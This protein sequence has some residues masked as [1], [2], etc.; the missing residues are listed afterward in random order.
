MTEFDF[1]QQYWSTLSKEWEEYKAEMEK[2]DLSDSDV[3]KMWDDLDL[4]I[5]SLNQ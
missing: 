2:F 3:E 4:K 1:L 5:D